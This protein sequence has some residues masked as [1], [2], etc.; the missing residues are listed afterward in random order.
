M[1]RFAVPFFVLVI[2]DYSY[3]A[4]REKCIVKAK[5]GLKKGILTA[6]GIMISAISNSIASKIMGG[7]LI[8]CFQTLLLGMQQNFFCLTGFHL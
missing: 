2:G 1:T 5:A 7:C 4:N 6:S 8:G 3:N